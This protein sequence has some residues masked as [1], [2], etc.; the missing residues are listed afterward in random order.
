MLL[1]GSPQREAG[2]AGTKSGSE[3]IADASASRRTS[4]S[5]LAGLVSDERV[6][7]NQ[8]QHVGRCSS[9]RSRWAACS[10]VVVRPLAGRLWGRLRRF[11]R[12]I[13]VARATGGLANHDRLLI[14]ELRSRRPRLVFSLAPRGPA[15]A[16][17]LLSRIA[18]AASNASRSITTPCRPPDS[19]RRQIRRIGLTTSFVRTGTTGGLTSA[20]TMRSILWGMSGRPG[21][22]SSRE[23]TCETG[24]SATLA[25]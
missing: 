9:R 10:R 19:G 8:I 12:S 16:R 7:R 11:G 22:S 20:T 14:P 15:P 18:W 21:R 17:R 6:W 25:S 23:L 3:F 24:T 4:L 13:D 1:D 5:I 2:L